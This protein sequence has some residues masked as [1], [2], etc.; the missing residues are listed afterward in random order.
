[1]SLVTEE[2]ENARIAL[3]LK[4]SDIRLLSPEE[5]ANLYSELCSSFVKG[6]DRKWWWESFKDIEASCVVKDGMGYKIIPELVPDKNENLWFVV[7]ED[8]LE[9]YPIFETT[10]SVAAAIIGECYGFEYYLIPKDKT[11]LLCENHD[12]R[13]IGVVNELIGKL[14]EVAV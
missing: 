1:M 5:N 9:F 10:A 13:L 12:N 6:G 8:Q 3:G 11:W 2:I 14:G 4:E 7:E